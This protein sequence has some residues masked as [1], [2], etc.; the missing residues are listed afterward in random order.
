[1]LRHNRSMWI[2]A[3]YDLSDFLS[4][5]FEK[6]RTFF[7]FVAARSPNIKQELKANFFNVKYREKL[8][9]A[10]GFNPSLELENQAEIDRIFYEIAL[11][12]HSLLDAQCRSWLGERGVTDEQILKHKIGCNVHYNPLVASLKAKSK[13]KEC[14]FYPPLIEIDP[15]KEYFGKE[16]MYV[17]TFPFFTIDGASVTNLCCRILDND[18]TDIF[19]FFFSHGRTSL[20]NVNNVDLTKPFY[21][22]EGVFDTL[23]AEHHGI[24]SVALGSSSVSE[25]QAQFLVK[26]PNAIL[27]LDGDIAGRHGMELSAF[28]KHHLP[29]GYDPDDLLREKP[30]YADVLRANL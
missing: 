5:T 6:N 27:C 22:F 15:V 10:C 30:E 20:F 25:E 26:Y 9:T 13:K 2:K 24:P 16:T 23:T 17:M 14:F 4:W 7:D 28:K 11:Y 18:Y 3:T 12:C 21:V 29:Q 19:K 8:L 1:M